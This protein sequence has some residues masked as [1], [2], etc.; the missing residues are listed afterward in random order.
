[1]RP[2]QLSMARAAIGVSMAE[3]GK[4]VGVSKQAISLFEKGDTGRISDETEFKIYDWMSDR[5]VYFGP[6]DSVSYGVNR[7]ENDQRM[8]W[9]LI[10]VLGEAGL[11]PA[12][13]ELLRRMKELEPKG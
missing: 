11:M 9:A 6:G 2:R 13:D 7:Y 8:I 4:A 12:S 10:Q 1:M 3:L 5:D